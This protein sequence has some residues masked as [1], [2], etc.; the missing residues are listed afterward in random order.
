MEQEDMS[1]LP[2]NPE[3]IEW[4]DVTCETHSGKSDSRRGRGALVVERCVRAD[5]QS[6]TLAVNVT[7]ASRARLT[8]STASISFADADPDTNPTL[9]APALN[10]NVGACTAATSLV[11]LTLAGPDFTSGSDVI[12]IGNLSWTA[13]AAGFV[14]GTANTTA[15]PVGSW[16]GPGARTSA[17]TYSLV[18]S[19][20]YVPGTYATTL[21]YTLTVP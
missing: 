17:Q 3:G 1:P 8:L 10:V 12:A 16:T 7:V 11:T 13:P 2:V 6:A 9:T 18:N 15:T 4:S 19:W 20:A 21:T 5:T 14:S